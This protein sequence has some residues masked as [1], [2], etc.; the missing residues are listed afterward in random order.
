MARGV[1]DAREDHEAGDRAVVACDDG[2]MPLVPRAFDEPCAP[3]WRVRLDRAVASREPTR[4]TRH[5]LVLVAFGVRD[6]DGREIVRVDRRQHVERDPMFVVGAGQ[7]VAEP[8]VRLDH[9]RVERGERCPPA[10]RVVHQPAEARRREA[11]AAPFGLG[12]DP[13]HARARE[14]VPPEPLREGGLCRGRHDPVVDVRAAHVLQREGRRA[15]DRVFHREVER[16]RQHASDLLA[17]VFGRDPDV[18]V[19]IGQTQGVAPHFGHP[20][21]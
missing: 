1:G 16:R 17:V 21:S 8:S 7:L 4:V 12:R 14:V 11:G 20:S 18:G 2:T 3:E 9:G 5:D 13:P 10:P 15:R 6:L 19:H